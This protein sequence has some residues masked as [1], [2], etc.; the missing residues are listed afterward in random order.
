MKFA[1]Y[2]VSFFYKKWHSYDTAHKVLS[3][4]SSR[5]PREPSAEQRRTSLS[6][7]EP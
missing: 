3:A 1:E 4:V 6:F 5:E 7:L 2:R